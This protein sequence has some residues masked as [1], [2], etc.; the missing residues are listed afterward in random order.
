MG[1]LSEE[2]HDLVN[3]LGDSQRLA[4]KF[5]P[6]V[7]FGTNVNSVDPEPGPPAAVTV[8]GPGQFHARWRLRWEHTGWGVYEALG[9]AKIETAVHMDR[10]PEFCH[11][12]EDI[13]GPGYGVAIIITEDCQS[14]FGL[15][16]FKVEL[17]AAEV[18]SKFKKKMIERRCQKKRNIHIREKI[19]PHENVEEK[20]F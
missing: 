13:L 12:I 8:C 11:G 14:P 17:L 1:I 10:L 5:Q 15:A 16:V 3:L 4:S 6:D 9:E 2:V 7:L 18:G 19:L 20:G